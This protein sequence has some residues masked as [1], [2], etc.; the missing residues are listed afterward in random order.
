MMERPSIYDIAEQSFGETIRLVEHF[1]CVPEIIHFSNYLSYNGEIKPL[2]EKSDGHFKQ[3]LVEH[4]VFGKRADNGKVNKIEAQEIASL[5]TAMTKDPSYSNLSIGVISL[6]GSHQTTAIDTLLQTHLPP[7][8]YEKHNIL[9]G[10][11]ANFQGDERDV[12]FLSMIDSCDKPPLRIVQSDTYKKR[13]NVAASRAKD[14][15]WVVHSLNYDTDLQSGD[16]RQR[17]ISHIRNPHSTAEKI[18]SANELADSDFEKRVQKDLI[19][20]GYHITPQWEV[21]S[22]RIDIVVH[23]GDKRMAIECDGDKHHTDE[24]LADD[25]NRQG[26]FRAT[27]MEIHSHQ[28]ERILSA[29]RENHRKGNFYPK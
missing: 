26:I 13:Y 3:S 1:R 28:G 11:S 14:Q 2:R 23:C 7:S 29:P 20:R 5:V 8:V 19:T 17:L 25:I 24:N 15:L 16:L 12:I 9:C 10:D 21:G 27:W 4:R 18:S 6:L 22:F